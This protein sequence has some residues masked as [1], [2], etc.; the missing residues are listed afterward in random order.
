MQ[1]PVVSQKLLIDGVVIIVAC[2]ATRIVGM[3]GVLYLQN[4]GH[5][6]SIVVAINLNNISEFTL[7]LMS[8]GF[9]FKHIERGT[10][11]STILAFSAMAVMAP[12]E[13]YSSHIIQMKISRVLTACHL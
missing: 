8:L 5:R 13:V 10:M 6:T 3:F 4:A 2:L 9:T 12:Y 1:I 7:V 11:T